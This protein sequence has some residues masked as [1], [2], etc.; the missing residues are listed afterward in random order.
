MGSREPR[1]REA[2]RARRLVSLDHLDETVR[3]AALLTP[4]LQ[5]VEKTYTRAFGGDGPRRLPIVLLHRE[6]MRVCV[7]VF[8]WRGQWILILAGLAF[9]QR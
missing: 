2:A 1:D 5:R 6:S 7:C 8:V 3:F 4:G 9:P